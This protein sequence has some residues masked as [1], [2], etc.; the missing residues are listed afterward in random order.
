MPYNL[1]KKRK[2]KKKR[3]LYQETTQEPTEVLYPSNIMYRVSTIFAF[4]FPP[5]ALRFP[6]LE[7]RK[8]QRDR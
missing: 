8:R 2:K 5:C 6:F 7:S 1:S 4:R 3:E